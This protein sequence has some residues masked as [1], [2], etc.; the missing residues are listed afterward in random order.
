M[1]VSHIID[2]I[3][4]NFLAG[5]H[6]RWVCGTVLIIV[7]SE[8]Y[9]VHMADIFVKFADYNKSNFYLGTKQR[10]RSRR[11]STTAC[12]WSPWSQLLFGPRQATRSVVGGGG[13]GGKVHCI[14]RPNNGCEGGLLMAQGWFWNNVRRKVWIDSCNI[15]WQLQ[16]GK[17]S[18]GKKNSLVNL[19]RMLS[20][21]RRLWMF[22]FLW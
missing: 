8:V 6:K 22:L 12:A 1:I 13:R 5:L 20:S 2:F 16:W 4:Y 14:W 21:L 3:H 11:L 18:Y 19:A 17:W 7:D 9:D 15:S 10:L